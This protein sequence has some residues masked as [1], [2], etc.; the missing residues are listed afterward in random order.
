[1]KK[2]LAALFLVTLLGMPVVGQSCCAEKQQAQKQEQPKE[3]CCADKQVKQQA[4]KESC[5]AKKSVSKE[6]V[7]KQTAAKD[8]TG[9]N[10]QTWMTPP[11][12]CKKGCKTAS[13]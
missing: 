3:S 7:V 8:C 5:C 10:Q 4:E 6:T 13:L 9:C 11:A 2:I 1:M 12:E